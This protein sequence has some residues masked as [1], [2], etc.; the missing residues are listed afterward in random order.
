MT[1]GKIDRGSGI[2]ASEVAAIAGLS[3]WTTPVEVWLEKV[4]LGRPRE[5]T[6]QMRA[7]RDLERAILHLGGRDLDRK[8]VGN[9]KTFAHARWPEVRLFATP[10]GFG[11]RRWT[12]AEVKVVSHRLSDWS[13]GPP[14]YVALQVQA[15]LAVFPKAGACDVIALVGGGVRT[16]RV[17]RDPVVVAGIEDR[18]AGWWADHIVGDRA[19]DPVTA[20][21]EWSLIRAR[22]VPDHQ[23]RLATNEEQTVG[24]DLV[25][26]LAERAR[27]DKLIDD[28]R[29]TL[30][31]GSDGHDV[32]GYGWSGKWSTRASVDWRGVSAASH[33]PDEVVEAFT[34][35]TLAFTVRRHGDTEPEGVFVP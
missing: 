19:P 21:D 29:R 13:D 3:P 28:G 1:A 2:G 25:G 35:R 17:D 8:L 22:L 33:I 27:L 15:Q 4:G 26:L 31:N 5:D 11:E 24:R 16:Y 23:E 10:D 7:G 32:A 34:R 20:E 18:V 12:L 14:P 9:R 30:A 6:P